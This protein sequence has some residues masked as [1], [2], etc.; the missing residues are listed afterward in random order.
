M[1]A[2]AEVV[3]VVGAWL[4]FFCGKRVVL[5]L[6]LAI[7]TSDDQTESLALFGSIMDAQHFRE[8][9][10]VLLRLADGLSSNNLGRFQLMEL[11]EDLKRARELEAQAT[12]QP[13]QSE[14]Y[15]AE[16][17]GGEENQRA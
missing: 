5:V 17:A 11:A 6:S 13:S 14:M 3:A 7:V 10:D 4:R 12:L 2:V 8:K 1:A 9:A 16:Y 15:E